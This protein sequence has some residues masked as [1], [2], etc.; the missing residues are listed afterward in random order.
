[1]PNIL[2]DALNSIQGLIKNQNINIFTYEVKNINGL[3]KETLTKKLNT[4]AHIQP[5]TPNELKK[6]T[7]S[8][9]DS[10]ECYKFFILGNNAE[11]LSSLN[12]PLEKSYF[13]WNTR[14]FKIYAKKDWHLNG[15]ICLYATLSNI[16]L[17]AL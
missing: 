16:S 14:A 6:F 12:I 10:I 1:M 4:S 15:W 13:E 3:P 7:D 11:L 5:I 9:I 17:N 2:S 8:T